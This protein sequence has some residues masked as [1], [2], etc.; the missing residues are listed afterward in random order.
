MIYIDCPQCAKSNLVHGVENIH[1]K[2]HFVCLNCKARLVV[3]I[4]FVKS[5]LKERTEE[6]K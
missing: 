1:D 6:Q 2:Q 3:K 4:I 5:D